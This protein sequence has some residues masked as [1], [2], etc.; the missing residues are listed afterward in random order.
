M[1]HTFGNEGALFMNAMTWWDH[2]TLSVWSQPWGAAIEGELLG[3]QLTLVPF[4]LVPWSV[5]LERNPDTLVLVDERANLSFVGQIPHDKFVIGVSIGEDATGFY[6]RSTANARVVNEAIGSFPVAVFADGETREIDVFLR[7]P[8]GEKAKSADVPVELT[9]EVDSDGTVTD[10]ETGSVWDIRLGVATGGPL[11]GVLL[12]RA[13]FVSAFDWAW[14]DF[15][16]QTD[17][18]GSQE[19]AVIGGTVR[20]K[21]D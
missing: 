10:V 20:S 17:F 16:P 9:F 2:E 1:P 13:P 8:E 7:R 4:D 6:F 19:D 14:R 15:F 3:T 11:R 12:Q 21:L 18:W 5:W